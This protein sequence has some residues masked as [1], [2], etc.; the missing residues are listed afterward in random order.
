[1]VEEDLAVE[2]GFREAVGA[3]VEFL[4]VARRPRCRADRDWRGSGRACGRR[5]SASGRAPNRASPGGCRPPSDRCALGLRLGGDL[6]A[7]GLFDFAQ[8]PSSAEVSS[9]RGVSGQL[10]RPQDGPSAFLR[11]SAGVSF[12]LLK[13]SCHSASTEAGSLLVAGV[14]F[15]DIGGVGALQKRREGKGGVRVLAR[16]GWRPGDF[17]SA[18]GKRR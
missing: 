8:L 16:H 9:S 14:E 11:T 13:N 1:M 5:G 18:H 7:D 6:G 12:R 2:I 10:S 17:E 15:V 3:R 4:A